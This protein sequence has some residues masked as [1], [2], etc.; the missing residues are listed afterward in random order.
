MGG[1]GFTFVV[2]D[3]EVRGFQDLEIECLIADLILSEIL[4]MKGNRKQQDQQCTS[5]P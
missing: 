2:V 4:R 3:I 1:V 5:Q